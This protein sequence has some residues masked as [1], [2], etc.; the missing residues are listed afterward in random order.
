MKFQSL[1]TIDFSKIKLVVWDLDE[2]FWHGILSEEEVSC[3]EEHC[4]LIQEL[5]RR[6]IV[7]SISSKNDWEQA[8]KKLTELGVWDFFVFCSINWQPKGQQ[9]QQMLKDMALRPENTL[10][11][12]DNPNN[13][14][15]AA[16]YCPNIMTA[17]P[18][19][20]P[21]LIQFCRVTEE[22]DPE[23]TRLQRYKILEQKRESRQSF[24]SNEEFLKNCEIRVGLHT[25]CGEETDRIYELVQRTNQLNFTKVRSEKEELAQLFRD[26][27]ASCGYVTASDRFGDYGIVGFYAVKEKKLLHFLFSCRTLGM[28]IEQYVYEQLGFPELRTEGSVSVLLSAEKK[29]HAIQPEGAEKAAE[30]KFHSTGR[31]L[32]KGPCDLEQI[33]SFIEKGETIDTE[34]T[35]VSRN[36]GEAIQYNHT[37]TI[38]GA[39]DYGERERRELARTGLSEPKLFETKLFDGGYDLV[40]LSLLPDY[41]LGVYHNK[42]DRRLRFVFG[43]AKFP[44]TEREF[45]PGYQNKTLYTAEN[46]FTREQLEKIEADYEAEGM[47]SEEELYRNLCEIRKRLDKRTRLILLNGS[48]LPFLA[49]QNPAYEGREE[50]HRRYNAVANR[51]ASG[52]ENTAVLDINPFLTGQDCFTDSISHFTKSVYYR[53]AMQ[54]VELIQ[55]NGN[56][57]NTRPKIFILLEEWKENLKPALRPILKWLRKNKN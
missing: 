50:I 29:E 44:L 25:Q 15:E 33:F 37:L 7:N 12:D 3:P 9:I 57:A 31:I 11:L 34:F 28:G 27:E 48:E 54:I 1:D 17:L 52:Q 32:F 8:K 2:T 35:Y 21:Q 16:F 13:L 24:S 30:K 4:E 45:W 26:P 43:D 42:K 14:E 56:Q 20:V 41:G 55:K 5:T 23:E 6:G 10:F 51:F 47:I 19:A 46:D 39:E 49:N 22:T 40:F 38:L 53:L 36:I 18:E